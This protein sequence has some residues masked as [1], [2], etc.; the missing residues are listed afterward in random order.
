MTY[1]A[2]LL[3]ADNQNMKDDVG[4]LVDNVVT[5]IYRFTQAT[6]SATTQVFY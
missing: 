1:F 3:K 4:K 5:A 2:D 6:A